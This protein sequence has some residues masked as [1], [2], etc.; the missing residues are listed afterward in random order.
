M[1]L[2]QSYDYLLGEEG[3]V[4]PGTFVLVPFGP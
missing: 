2:D 4:E 3:P 1:A